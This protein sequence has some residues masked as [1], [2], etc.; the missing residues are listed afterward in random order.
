M[1]VLLQ[2]LPGLLHWCAALSLPYSPYWPNVDPGRAH[3]LGSDTVQCILS[4]RMTTDSPSSR[5]ER[6]PESAVS[7]PKV[8]VLLSDLEP[9]YRLERHC[10]STGEGLCRETNSQCYTLLGRSCREIFRFIVWG[11]SLLRLRWFRL[12]AWLRQLRIWRS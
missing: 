3:R 2:S 9:K 5:L 6:L 10:P 8:L 7:K 1:T 11:R 12:F 4:P